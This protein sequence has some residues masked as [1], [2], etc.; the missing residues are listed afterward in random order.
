MR[1]ELSPMQSK[2]L[3]HMIESRI[4]SLGE[5]DADFALNYVLEG[6][7]KLFDQPDSGATVSNGHTVATPPVRLVTDAKVR[8]R[9]PMTLTHSKEN[10]VAIAMLAAGDSCK[11]VAYVL[12]W[13]EMKV[14]LIKGIG[15]DMIAKLEALP[16]G[17]ERQQ[18]LKR[19]F[20]V[21]S[22]DLRVSA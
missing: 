2:V 11:D 20:G 6:I 8:K 4:A 10:G 1:L 17:Y 7:V 21:T 22:N 19:E 9:K 13:P 3:R 12:G 14:R 15:K 16:H 18:F 5:T